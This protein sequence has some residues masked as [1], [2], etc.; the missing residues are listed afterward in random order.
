MSESKPANSLSEL[1]RHLRGEGFGYAGNMDAQGRQIWSNPD[2]RSA[3]VW[4]NHD[5]NGRKTGLFYS[6]E[7]KA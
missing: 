3:F 1:S 7:D 4:S 6:I 5:H 2:G